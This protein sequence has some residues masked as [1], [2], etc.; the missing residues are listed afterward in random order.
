MKLVAKQLFIDARPEDVYELLTDAQLL[1][2][3]M[4]PIAHTEPRPGGTITW[5][6]ANGDTVAGT[7]RELVPGRRIVFTY[8]WDRDDVG[9]PHGSTTVRRWSR[10]SW[11]RPLGWAGSRRS[12]SRWP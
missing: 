3:W 5:T 10:R 8:G 9:I 7:F 11:W 12:G 6:H 4:A 1:V 2:E